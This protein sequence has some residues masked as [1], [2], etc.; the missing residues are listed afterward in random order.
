M[1]TQQTCSKKT[2]LNSLVRRKGRE[3][4]TGLDW[5]GLK[6]RMLKGRLRLRISA[7]RVVDIANQ[8]T[9]TLGETDPGRD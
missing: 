5:R 3:R 9:E 1:R 4:K 8:D 6:M 2:D 7:A